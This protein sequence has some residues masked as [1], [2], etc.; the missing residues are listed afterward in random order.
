[1]SQASFG[2]GSSAAVTDSLPRFAA[3]TERLVGTNAVFVGA[4]IDS[5]DFVRNSEVFAMRHYT[6]REANNPYLT[7]SRR[8]I[9]G[10]RIDKGRRQLQGR[11]PLP[12]A[13]PEVRLRIIVIEIDSGSPRS[14]AHAGPIDIFDPGDLQLKLTPFGTLTIYLLT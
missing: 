3:T 13:A 4:E 5:G 9:S 7:I 2:S 8:Y 1:V 12:N 14:T 6:K 11:Y 10:H